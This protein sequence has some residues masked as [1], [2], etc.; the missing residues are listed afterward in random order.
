MCGKGWCVPGGAGLW[1]RALGSSGALAVAGTP[2]D[3]RDGQCLVHTAV[4]DTH[5]GHNRP[6]LHAHVC[7]LLQSCLTLGDPVDRRPPGS[8]VHGVS[9]QEYWRG[10]PCPP[11]GDLPN[12][13]IE[14][15]SL[16][17][18]ALIGGFFPSAI[19]E[20]LLHIHTNTT[21]QEGT[22]GFTE[23][24]ADATPSQLCIW[25][26]RT[27]GSP[28]LAAHLQPDTRCAQMHAD[29]PSTAVPA[30]MQMHGHMGTRRGAHLLHH[31]VCHGP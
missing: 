19:W 28:T 31:S 7:K 20:A 14:P 5:R 12:P 1:L 4:R 13:G 9:R 6:F 29:P 16:T 17:S 21:H 30:G 11:P 10:L 25:C 2:L 22:L 3:P 24:A 26:A 15:R 23:A 18:P 8:S 27:A